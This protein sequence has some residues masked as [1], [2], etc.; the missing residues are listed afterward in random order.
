LSS[1]RIGGGSSVGL[2]VDL[3]RKGALAWVHS[4]VVVAGVSLVGVW[5]WMMG[6]TGIHFHDPLEKI[7]GLGTCGVDVRFII[8][9]LPSKYGYVKHLAVLCDVPML[10]PAP[11][12][13]V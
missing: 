11:P 9:H 8:L 7:A 1:R 13:P 10:R 3:G 4:A 6:V 5:I 12:L 2:D